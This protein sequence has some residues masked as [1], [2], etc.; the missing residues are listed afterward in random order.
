M[1][2]ITKSGEIINFNKLFLITKGSDIA[3]ESILN[4]ERSSEG[5]GTQMRKLS[6]EGFSEKYSDDNVTYM[7]KQTYYINFIYDSNNYFSVTFE[8]ENLCI[9]AL[10]KII[11]AYKNNK[12]YIEI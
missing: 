10:E 1:I 9:E 2:I 6:S 11:N 7:E 5:L 8:D 4:S 3:E 12:P